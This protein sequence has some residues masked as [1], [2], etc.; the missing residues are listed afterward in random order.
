MPLEHKKIEMGSG[1]MSTPWMIDIINNTQQHLDLLCYRN[2]T[3]ATGEVLAEIKKIAKY[4]QVRVLAL[5]PEAD[6][7]IQELTTQYLPYKTDVADLSS[8]LVESI[9]KTERVIQLWSEEERKNFSHKYY[10]SMPTAHFVRSDDRL[11]IGFPNLLY[12]AQSDLMS[13][14]PFIEVNV[15][16]D[17]GYQYMRHYEYLWDNLT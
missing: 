13:E 10:K 2:V 1:Y 8:D 4:C 15:E 7:H 14:R 6:E 5:S 11:F 16:S 9:K 12:V 17:L 3:C